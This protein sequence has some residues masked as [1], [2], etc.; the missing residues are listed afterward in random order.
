MASARAWS[1]LALIVWLLLV[2]ATDAKHI[3]YGAIGK[4]RVPCKSKFSQNCRPQ[5]TDPY[6][7]GCSK[8]T[9]CRG[10]PPAVNEDGSSSTQSHLQG[11]RR[12]LYEQ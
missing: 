7:R 9:R 8:L 1:L 4:D 5:P 12:L 2:S 3:G 6:T 11:V 10:G